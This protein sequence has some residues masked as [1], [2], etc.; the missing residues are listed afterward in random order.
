MAEILDKSMESLSFFWKQ[1]SIIW[2]NDGLRFAAQLSNAYEH[3][4]RAQLAG[5]QTSARWRLH[6]QVSQTQNLQSIC[7]SQMIDSCFKQGV[8]VY[9]L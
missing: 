9:Q 7:F 2:K 6:S 3:A 4:I 8:L 5:A 1:K